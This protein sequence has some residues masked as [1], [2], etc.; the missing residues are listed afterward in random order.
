[1]E[2]MAVT[3]KDIARAAGVSPSTVS[4]ALNNSPLIREETKERIRRIAA[5]LGYERNE[6]A[7]SLVKGKSK[8]LG[9]IVA[10][11]TNP[12]FAE[13]A[14]GVE[15]VAHSRGYGLI[16]CNTGEDPEKER[17]YSL[18]LRRKRVDGLIITSVTLE[19]PIL[20]DLERAGVPFVLVSRVSD[21]VDAPYIIV[22]DALGARLAAEH[23]IG[24]GHHRIA[25]ISGPTAVEPG[26]VRAEAFRE[27]LGA[28]GVKVPG[29]WV[30]H[31]DFSWKGGEAAARALL[32]KRRRPTAI[33]AANDL[34]ALGVLTAAHE[35]GLE[36]PGDLSVVGFDDITYASL[37]LIRLTTVAQPVYEMARIA[38]GWLIDVIEGKRRRKLRRV[39]RPRLIVRETTAPPPS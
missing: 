31:T 32:S 28:H 37:P 1:M 21:T 12:F 36:V 13:V 29:T 8:A 35:L 9:L 10:D 30:V 26:K 20:S 33:F 38:A 19:D 7:Q 3:I 2:K 15:E 5:Q 27:T 25:C 16:L 14:K 39:M 22:D 34:L 11:I 23:L 17:S 18:L 24:L 6:L 4:R